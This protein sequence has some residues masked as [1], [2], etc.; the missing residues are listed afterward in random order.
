MKKIYGEI[1]ISAMVFSI[2]VFVSFAALADVTPVDG[3]CYE[4]GS[5]APAFWSEPRMWNFDTYAK[6]GGIATF[7]STGFG[8]NEYHTPK[9]NAFMQNVEALTLGGFYLKSLVTAFENKDI[10]MVGDR[11]F[12]NSE[13]TGSGSSFKL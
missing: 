3:T 10:Q 5:W 1:A 2:A 4:E 7:T 13:H 9:R 11:P 8:I 12:I 6:D